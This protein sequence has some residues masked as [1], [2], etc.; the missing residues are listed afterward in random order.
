MIKKILK[1]LELCV[2]ISLLYGMSQ[3]RSVEASSV[4]DEL[5]LW[6]ITD[7]HHLSPTLY[8]EGPR[9]QEMQTTGAG[10]EIFYSTERLQALTY[11]IEHADNLPHALIISGDLTLNG[12]YMSL[13]ELQEIFSEIEQLGTEVYVIPG[14]HDIH[15]GWA[16]SFTESRAVRNKQITPQDFKE[17][18]SS[19]G[20]QEAIYH[21]VSSL[22][23][24]T[25]L[26]DDHWLVML[27][28]NIYLNEFNNQ[29]PESKG[30]LS[31]ETLDWLSERLD[32]I[33]EEDVQVTLVLHHSSISHI[34]QF[35]E[36]FVVENSD[37]L[38]EILEEHHIPVTLSGHMHAQHIGQYTYQDNTGSIAD[39]ATGAFSV[40]PSVIGEIT[41]GEYGGSYH[42]VLLE[43]EHWAQQTMQVDS[44]ILNYNSYIQSVFTKANE[45]INQNN[46]D[47]D[48]MTSLA[49]ELNLAFFAGN[50][51]EIWEATVSSYG[52]TIESI[53]SEEVSFLNSYLLLLIDQAEL[54]HKEYKWN[55]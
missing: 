8:E 51:S 39:I 53:T 48:D 16:S 29:P 2:L 24:I 12:E 26:R 52:E 9:I 32:L 14:N 38:T 49:K 34:E 31:D 21:D 11:Q 45:H 44:N 17:L 22:S 43:V 23:Y 1:L 36:R 6:V 27:D 25:Q 5:R 28:S 41:I 7:L 54:N 50:I 4:E 20:Y 13:V 47:S 46:E 30:R 19:F 55:Y 10:L 35:W 18:M 33:K 15:N 3:E 42:Q 40:Q 37:R